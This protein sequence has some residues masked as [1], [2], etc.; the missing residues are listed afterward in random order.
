MPPPAF[1]ERLAN[2]QLQE[3]EREMSALPA[4]LVTMVD[5]AIEEEGG[6]EHPAAVRKTVAALFSAK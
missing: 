4:A 5:C 6:L 3:L 1:N 2:A